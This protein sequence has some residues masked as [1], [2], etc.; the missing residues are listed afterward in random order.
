MGIVASMSIFKSHKLIHI[1]SIYLLILYFWSSDRKGSSFCKWV[2]IDSLSLAPFQRGWVAE[3]KCLLRHCLFL[4]VLFW[5]GI[6]FQCSAT[7]PLRKRCWRERESMEPSISSSEFG[8]P[9]SAVYCCRKC[10]QAQAE[11]W[12]QPTAKPA[13]SAFIM[14]STTVLCIKW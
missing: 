11:K 13:T 7:Q 1:I 10:R 5:V 12:W 4:L 14:R 3:H 2:Y 6:R 8:L 9:S